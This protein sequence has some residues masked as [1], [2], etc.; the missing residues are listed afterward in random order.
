[1][2]FDEQIH[3][4]LSLVFFNSFEFAKEH[5]VQGKTVPVI[6]DNDELLKLELIKSESSDGIFTGKIMFFV[7][8]S[9]LDFEP[10]VEQYITFDGQSYKV[11]DTKHDDGIYTIVIEANRS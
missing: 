1:M 10:F 9:E 7:Q 3:Q 8:E 4:D 11:T 5:E 6:M 2:T